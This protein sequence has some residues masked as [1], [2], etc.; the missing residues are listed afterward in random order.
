MI[1]R[2]WFQRLLQ[3]GLII[4]LTGCGATTGTPVAN[5]VQTVA[6]T[7]APTIVPLPKPSLTESPQFNGANAM[8]FAKVQMQWIPRDTGTPGWQA[9]GD[10]IVQTLLEYGWDVEEQFFN[11]PENKKGRNII[12]RRGTGPLVLLGAHYDAR[13]YADNDPDPTKRMQPVPAANDGASGVAVLL[14]LARVL[15][16][17]RLNEEVWLVFFD[18]EDNGGIG[19]W[20]WT[21]GSIDLAPKLETTPK[22]VVIVDMIGDADQQV[23]LEQSSTPALRAEIWQQ[24]ADLGYTTFISETKHHILDDHTAFLQRG[25]SAADLIDFDYPHWHTTSDTIDKLSASALEAVGRTLEEWL[26][27]Q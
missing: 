8:E 3:L 4:S 12:A 6:A 9:N 25:F 13:R 24:A 17:E 20:N 21:L 16:P 23:Y 27:K 7:S 10:W 19:T 14:E 11:V 5:P 2:L 18:A 1:Q 26:T 15:K 22:A